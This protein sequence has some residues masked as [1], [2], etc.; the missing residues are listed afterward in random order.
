MNPRAYHKNNFKIWIPNLF[1]TEISLIPKSNKHL[2]W[3]SCH[4]IL[5]KPSWIWWRIKQNLGSQCIQ[6]RADFVAQHV[7][8]LAAMLT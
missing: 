4:I 1:F 8:P 6:L 7:T 5:C 3:A 2:N